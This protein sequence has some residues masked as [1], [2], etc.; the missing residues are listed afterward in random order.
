MIGGVKRIH[1]A[2]YAGERQRIY[3]LLSCIGIQMAV[4]RSFASMYCK[5]CCVDGA[6]GVTG[7]MILYDIHIVIQS[8]M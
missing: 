6:G 5:K 7:G 8:H 2:M 1:D 3:Y 4:L